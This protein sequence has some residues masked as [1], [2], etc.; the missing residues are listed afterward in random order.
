MKYVKFGNTSVQ[1]KEKLVTCASKMK[2]KN[3]ITGRR[4]I[5]YALLISA[6]LLISTA[7]TLD[8]EK[9]FY[10]Y[11]PEKQ[12]AMTGLIVPLYFDPNGSWDK[13]ISIHRQYPDVPMVVIINPDNGSGNNISG[14]YVY[15]TQ[16]MKSSGIIVLGYIY[17]SYGMRS[18][19]AIEQQALNYSAW[20]KVSGI[21]L[22]EV[23][24]NSSEAQFYHDLA[25]S[26]RAIGLGYIV[27]NPGTYS[28]NS[29]SS[30][31]NVTV[32]YE[33]PGL[34]GPGSF[35][36]IVNGNPRSNSSMISFNVPYLEPSWF[37]SATKYFSFVYITN[38]GL[39]NP[40]CGLPSYIMNEVQ[41]L[42]LQ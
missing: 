7:F 28:P 35:L 37:G 27:G 20:Y 26:I 19:D 30:C 9:N 38:L 33:N 13:L 29:I 23:S 31:F 4:V 17:T 8:Y 5:F 16:M 41:M 22:D 1:R 6:I 11:A 25:S 32:L 42:S 24:D 2:S 18:P 36:S 40:Y 34:P 12:Q 21:F 39:P 3:A 15:W 10:S 14:S